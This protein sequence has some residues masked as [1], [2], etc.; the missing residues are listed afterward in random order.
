MSSDDGRRRPV[1]QQWQPRSL[2][3]WTKF[4][5]SLVA[6]M[7]YVYVVV[8]VLVVIVLGP[9]RCLYLAVRAVFAACHTLRVVEQKATMERLTAQ[10]PEATGMTF[11]TQKPGLL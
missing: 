8:V 11:L 3:I 10:H 2:W 9:S 4:V 1:G 5:P 7:F 6:C